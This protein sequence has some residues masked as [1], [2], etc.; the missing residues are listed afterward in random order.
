MV[1][2][3]HPHMTTGKTIALT[4]QTFV[5][6]TMSL[7]FNM[8]SRLVVAF[9]SRI[10]PIIQGIRL[11]TSLTKEGRHFTI[12]CHFCGKEC[13]LEWPWLCH[14][15]P[16]CL[17]GGIRHKNRKLK[18]KVLVPWLLKRSR[19]DSY[20]RKSRKTFLENLWKL[21]SFDAAKIPSHILAGK[22][23]KLIFR[24]I[25]KERGRTWILR[26]VS[27]NRTLQSWVTSVYSWVVQGTNY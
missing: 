4:I 25:I 22:K 7:L 23:K 20:L 18:H 14:Q 2:L 1:Q 19:G 12:S 10:R 21:N 3:S 11:N 9:L 27:I 15:R 16:C 26:V 13:K 17:S 24:P 6:K 5:R 8:L